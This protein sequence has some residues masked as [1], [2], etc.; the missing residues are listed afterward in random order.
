[1][2][3]IDISGSDSKLSCD[4]IQGQ[5]GSVV[6]VPTGH[7]VAITDSGGLTLAG[8]AVKAGALGKVLQVVQTEK[9]DTFST[10]TNS[11][12]DVTGMSVTITPSA[13]GSKVLVLGHLEIMADNGVTSQTQL[14]RGTTAINIGAAAG[15]RTRATYNTGN[16]AGDIEG[17][18]S[19]SLCYLDS[20]ST[21]S[22]T[23]YK[24]Q[25]RNNGSGGAVYFNR[26]DADDDLATRGRFAST[27]V[28]QEIGA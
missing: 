16:Q 13:T 26:T 22:A 15:S 7:T 6:T 27:L 23:T 1:M 3:Q 2:P 19:V 14:L 4:K 18:N 20:P 17:G 21:T 9:T 5:S 28:V 24:I 25:I 12:V 8:T 10:T 11:F